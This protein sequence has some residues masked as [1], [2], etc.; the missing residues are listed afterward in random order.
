MYYT[1]NNLF[2]LSLEVVLE[3]LEK[4]VTT[5]PDNTQERLAELV[6]ATL[7][8]VEVT[9]QQGENI[10]RADLGQRERFEQEMTALRELRQIT[11]RQAETVSQQTENV[12]NLT[13]A[14]ASLARSVDTLARSNPP[15]LETSRRAVRASES[16]ELIATRILGELRDLIEQLR[17]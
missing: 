13:A 15:M 10:T 7:Q 1:G 11:E 5:Q 14:V 4:A 17:P 9:K 6:T 2:Q 8:L 3:E 16:T 12:R